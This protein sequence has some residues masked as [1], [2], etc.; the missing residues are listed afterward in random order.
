MLPS[1]RILLPVFNC[2]T[3]PGEKW[4]GNEDTSSVWWSDDGGATW[5]EAQVPGSL[6]CVHMN[7]VVRQDGSL[8]ACFRSR[9]ADHVWETTSTDDGLT[10]AEP[11]P[12]RAAQQ[13]LLDPGRRDR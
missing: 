6:G 5:T 2:I 7:I 8:W 1:G 3:V 11:D 9:W 13:Q 4:V 10:W 12:D